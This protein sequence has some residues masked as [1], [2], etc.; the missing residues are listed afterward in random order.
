M[1][2]QPVFGQPVFGGTGW[3]WVAR[4]VHRHIFAIY[5]QNPGRKFLLYPTYQPMVVSLVFAGKQTLR[6]SA[7]VLTA[8]TVVAARPGRLGPNHATMWGTREAECRRGQGAIGGWRGA[9]RPKR[10]QDQR[11]TAVH[12]AAWPK[13]ADDPHQIGKKYTYKVYSLWTVPQIMAQNW[14]RNVS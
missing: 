8:G 1:F 3:C 2:G 7:T 6:L 14:L 11:K 5:A 12:R 10:P 13:I 9:Q 4:G